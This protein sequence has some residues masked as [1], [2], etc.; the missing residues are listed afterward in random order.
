MS[1]SSSAE[2]TTR[3]GARAVLA[4]VGLA[5]VAVPYGLTLLLVEEEWAPLLRADLGT[6]QR[7]HDYA[8]IHAGFVRG[9]A[10]TVAALAVLAIGFSRI[11]LGVHY[12]SDVV[13]GFVHGRGVGSGHRGGGQEDA[14]RTWARPRGSARRARARSGGEPRRPPDRGRGT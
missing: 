3:F 8:V 13:G 4:A 5:L 2:S 1:S 7:L 12:V 10:V 9:T 6:S 14:R 11:A